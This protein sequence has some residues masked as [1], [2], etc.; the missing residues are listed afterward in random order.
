MEIKENELHQVLYGQRIENNLSLRK[1]KL[2]RELLKRRLGIDD[3]KYSINPEEII[4][5]EEYKNKKFETLND[6]LLFS[7]SIF[8]NDNSDTNDIKYIICLV[9][10]ITINEDKGEVVQSNIL[11]GIS[12]TLNKFIDDKVIVDQLLHILINFT[13]Y[14]ENCSD[15]LKKD[16]LSIFSNI[17]QKYQN[18]QII[19]SDLITALGNLTNDNIEAQNIFYQTK[20]FEEIYNMTIKVKSPQYKKDIGIFFLSNF[21][22]GLQKNR[23]FAQNSE[24]LIKLIDIMAYNLQFPDNVQM[25]LEALG[26]LSDI[27]NIFE[28]LVIKSEIFNFIFSNKDP[29][30]FFAS[31]RIIT[32][33]TSYDENINLYIINNYK[34]IPYFLNL[35]NSTS[36]II[37]GQILFLLGNMIENKPSKINEILK[38]NQIFDKIYEFLDNPYPDILDKVIYIMNIIT[39]FMNNGDILIL[40]QKDIHIKIL[41]ILKFDYKKEIKMKTIDAIVNFLVKDTQDG[42]IKQSF[43][44][45]GIKEIFANICLD[46]N[47]AQMCIKIEDILKNFFD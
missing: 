13:Y 9:K 11:S 42:L 33:V 19:F 21:C 41:N 16:Y 25:C 47:D 40:F 29:K 18:D 36:N 22:I 2:N 20:L 23:N 46:K 27:D 28:Y 6:I 34:A 5:K 24:I 12:K 37:K 3:A 17:S 14:L 8:L 45:N 4:I 44:D 7:A 32:N 43:I 15:L 1:K 39:T 10:K 35:L 26:N 30:Y 38:N 31:H